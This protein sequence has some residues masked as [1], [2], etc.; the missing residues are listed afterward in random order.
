MNA[1]TLRRQD[2]QMKFFFSSWRLGVL[3]F[4][5]FSCQTFAQTQP[6]T[7]RAMQPPGTYK[8]ADVRMRDVC[9][10]PDPATKTY[11]MI[12]PAFRVVRM[13]ASKDLVTWEGPKVIYQAPDDVWGD[14][15]IIGIWA[16][17]MHIYKGKYYLFLTFD[18]RH[19]LAEQ[20]RNWRPRVTRG[21]TILVSDS[22]MGPFKSFQN[23]STPPSDM[24]TL[25]GTLWVE[26]GVPYMVYSHEWVQITN[27]AMEYIP[28]KEDLSEAAGEPKAMFHASQAPWIKMGNDGGNYVTD[29]PYLYQ[30]KSGKLFMI[31]SGFSDGGYTTGIAISDSG[32]L[33]GP[34]K[35]QDQPLYDKDGGHG[36]LFTTF[37]GKL[38]MVLHS[39]NNR[40]A[41]PRIFEME[42]TGETL[43]NVREFTGESH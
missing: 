18:T 5:L 9:I 22:P 25:D 32:K 28:L 39:P 19:Q 17:E 7:R 2:R 4:I 8:L 36:M 31:W 33:A 34:W 15:P 35:Q 23:H 6:T 30:S 11:Y 43:R 41:R 26:H 27:G 21:S 40:D 37:D 29:G 38:I 12:G 24:M 10:R 42:D 16:P 1:K 3:A 20:W 13:Y 14:I